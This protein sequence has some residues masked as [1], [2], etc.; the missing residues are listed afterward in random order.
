MANKVLIHNLSAPMDGAKSA[1]IDIN[2]GSGNLI[3]DRLTNPGHVLANGTLEYLE[4]QDQPTSSVNTR[5]GQATLTINARSARQ[6]WLKLPWAACNG[7]TNWQIHLNPTMQSDIQASSGGGNVKLDLAG[8][9]ISHLV[10]D[11]GGGNTHVVLPDNA[12]NLDVTAK[13]GG[14]NV[15]VEIGSGTTGS[16]IVNATSGAGNVVVRVPSSMAARIHASSGMGKVI[17]DSRFSKVDNKTYMSPDFETAADKVE[18]T[19]TSG[20]GNV[21]INGK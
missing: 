8:M 13:T 6:T 1:K 9:L 7:A 5:N 19:A 14:G 21:S 20:A 3:I 18:I 16:S 11:T 15:T 4:N 10:A 2:T 17:M 12:A